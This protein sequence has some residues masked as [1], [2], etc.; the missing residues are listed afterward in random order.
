LISTLELSEV[1]KSFKT[2]FQIPLVPLHLGGVVVGVALGA[3]TPARTSSGAA[4]AVA[5]VAADPGAA[6][7]IATMVEEA[8]E[9]M[10][11]IEEQ[12]QHFS[13]PT[14]GK[15]I[16]SGASTMTEAE[17]AAE[18]AA[19]KAAA[20]AAEMAAG[21]AAEKAS[22][23]GRALGLLGLA[24]LIMFAGAEANATGGAALAVIVMSAAANRGWGAA[25]GAAT[26]AHLSSLWWG[27]TRCIQWTHSLNATGLH[28]KYDFLVSNSNFVPL[29]RGTS[30]RSPCSLRSSAPPSTSPSL[31]VGG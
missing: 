12:E 29:H 20:N 13:P 30:W 1:K 31:A 8:L 14:P 17:M 26:E 23:L 21:R 3:V 16:I 9:I 7:D 4:A 28:L 5:A 27:C 24:L 19:E 6:F 18:M 25:A 15:E 22:T 10:E 2:C 11:E